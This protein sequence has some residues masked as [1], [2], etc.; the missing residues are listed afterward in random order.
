MTAFSAA[1][2][3][4][5]CQATHHRALSAATSIAETVAH[6]NASD[7]PFTQLSTNLKKLGETVL[8]LGDRLSRHEVISPRLQQTLTDRLDKCDTAEA[9]VERGTVDYTDELIPIEERLLST[10]ESWTGLE[11]SVMQRLVEATQ[12]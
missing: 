12:M 3:A 1:A 9:I 8:E 4:A 2:L 7:F 5:Q 11:T 6:R 10:F